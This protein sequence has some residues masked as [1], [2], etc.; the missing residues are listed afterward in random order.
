MRAP[1]RRRHRTRKI[2]VPPNTDLVAIAERVTYVGSP[3]HKD[4]PSFAGQPKRRSDASLCPRSIRDADKV[5]QWLRSAIERGF[6]S[7]FWE[8]GYPRYVWHKQNETVYEAR[9]VNSGDGT[10]KGYPL[11]SEEWPTGIESSNA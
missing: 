7:A 3:E 2:Q 9:L 6:T 4:F 11:S 10:Y 1:N 5:T 8:K